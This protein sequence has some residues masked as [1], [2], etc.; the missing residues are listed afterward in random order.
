MLSHVAMKTRLA[1]EADINTIKELWYENF[2]D[3]D[4]KESIDFYF[5][6]NF[7]L[8]HTFVLEDSNEIITSLQLNQ[9]QLVIDNKIE[10]VSFVIGVATFKK[11]QRQGYMKVL[12]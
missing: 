5:D 3:H 12:L 4:S 7:D 1:N 2:L 6:N 9:H 10:N 8:K 11:Y